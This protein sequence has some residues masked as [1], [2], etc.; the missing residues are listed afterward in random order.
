MTCIEGDAIDFH[1]YVKKLHGPPE[2]QVDQKVLAELEA[3]FATVRANQAGD[4]KPI[5][6]EGAS[7]EGASAEGASRSKDAP[8]T[9]RNVIA[10]VLS[11]LK[12]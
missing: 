12:A 11:P 1:S 10:E 7:A 2:G 8:I 5:F 4:P 9:D 3:H 6:A